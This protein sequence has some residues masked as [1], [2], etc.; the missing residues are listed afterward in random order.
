MPEFHA[1]TNPNVK[2]A[3]PMRFCLKLWLWFVCQTKTFFHAAAGTRLQLSVF[4]PERELKSPVILLFQRNSRCRKDLKGF[5]QSLQLPQFH[6]N[7][8]PSLKLAI[9][10]PWPCPQTHGHDHGLSPCNTN[11]VQVHE[12][13]HHTPTTRKTKQTIPKLQTSFETGTDYY[14]LSNSSAHNAKNKAPLRLVIFFNS[15]KVMFFSNQPRF[16][17]WCF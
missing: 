3:A 15:L 2:S 4:K 16:P 7:A 8:K 6:A 13:L 11:K 10:I 14:P 1:N 5:C 12:N 9:Q 17:Q